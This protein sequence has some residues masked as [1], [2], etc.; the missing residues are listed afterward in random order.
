MAGSAE[1][2]QEGAQD[3]QGKVADQ[4]AQ[5]RY[6]RLCYACQVFAGN[7]RVAQVEAVEQRQT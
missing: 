6:S 1:Y 2:M 4:V 3:D 7:W 5:A